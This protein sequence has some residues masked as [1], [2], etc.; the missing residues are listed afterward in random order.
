[1]S[2]LRVETLGEDP[3][4]QQEDAHEFD[5]A[6]GLYRLETIGPSKEKCE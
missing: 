6:L 1:M 4:P 5:K 2:L 3:Y